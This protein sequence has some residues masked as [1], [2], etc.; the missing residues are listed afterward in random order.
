MMYYLCIWCCMDVFVC[1]FN[2]CFLFLYVLVLFFCGY[3]LLFCFCTCLK[4]FRNT[5][6]LFVFF[7][8]LLFLTYSLYGLYE[9]L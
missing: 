8:F 2:C 1:L 9:H 4:A 6:G 7:F 5:L 3:V